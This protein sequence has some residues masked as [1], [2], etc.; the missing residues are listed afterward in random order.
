MFLEDLEILFFSKLLTLHLH[1]NILDDFLANFICVWVL[2]CKF[3]N[4]TEACVSFCRKNQLCDMF[5]K[6]IRPR[7]GMGHVHL[8]ETAV[9]KRSN[10]MRTDRIHSKTTW[11]GK[12]HVFCVC[13]QER[14]E[15]CAKDVVRKADFYRRCLFERCKVGKCLFSL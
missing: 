1:G 9:K 7:N 4:L 6:W 3:V 15:A 2:L 11:H 10:G 14:A 12:S 8:Q 13:C 5:E